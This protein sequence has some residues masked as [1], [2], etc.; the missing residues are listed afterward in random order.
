[1]HTYLYIQK[2]IK[3]HE[4]MYDFEMILCKTGLNH[5]KDTYTYGTVKTVKSD[6][7]PLL[8]RDCSNG[9]TFL[10]KITSTLV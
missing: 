2:E 9:V 4:C 3:I 7:E 10:Y 5:I 8:F 6:Y 1:M